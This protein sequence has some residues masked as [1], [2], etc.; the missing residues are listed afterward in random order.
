MYVNDGHEDSEMDEICMYVCMYV[1]DGR[2]DG[3]AWHIHTLLHEGVCL[4]SVT[5]YSRDRQQNTC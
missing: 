3:D 1:L 5:S 4:V 2:M